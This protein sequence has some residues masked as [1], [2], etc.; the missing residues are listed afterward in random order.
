MLNIFYGRENIDKEK[1]IFDNIGGRA[2]LLVPDQFTLEAE[3]DLFEYSG[4]KAL[5][6]IEILS[7]SRLGYRLLSEL[8]GSKRTFIDKYGRHMILTEIAAREKDKLQ[9]F[10]GLEEKNSFIELVNNFI[11]ELKQYNCGSRELASIIDQVQDDSYVS[12]KLKDLALL[13]GAYEK[14]IEGKYTDSEDYIDL[15]MGKIGQSKL[16]EGNNIWIY[17]FDS[18]APKALPIIGELVECA[19]SVNVVLAG[20]DDLSAKDSQL[21]DLFRIV[22]K[23]LINIASKKGVP[24][25]LKPVPSDY[26]FTNKACGITVLEKELYA[27]P[28]KVVTDPSSSVGLT[29]TVAANP[30]NEAE[31]AASYVLHLVRD[32]G[33]KFNEI[34]VV[35]NDTQIRGSILKR[36]FREYGLDLI[37]DTGKDIL[38]NHIIQYV[39]SLIDVVVEKYR[40]SSVIRVLKSGFCDLTW[41]EISDLENYIIKYR[42]KG[43]MWK[44]PFTKGEKEYGVE[45]LKALDDIRFAAIEPLTKFEEAFKSETNKE[46]I[47]KL[48]NF[49]FDTVKLPDKIETLIKEQEAAGRL[50]LS[51]ETAQIWQSLVSIL[52]QMSEIDGNGKFDPPLF[53]QLLQAGLSQ[54]KLGVLPPAIDGLIMGTMQRTRTGKIRALLVVGANEGILPQEKPS[55]GLF[56]PEEKDLFKNKGVELCKSENIRLMEERLAIYR[57]LSAPSEMLWI[58]ASLTDTEGN[59]IK[60]SSVFSAVSGIFTCLNV[61]RDILSYEDSIDLVS[62]GTAGLRHMTCALQAAA[63]GKEFNSQWKLAL[64]WYK[65]NHSESIDSIRRGISFSNSQEDLGRELASSLFKKDAREDLSLSP[66]RLEKF[67]RCPFSHFIDYGLKPEERRIFEVAPRE[68]GD[69]YHLCLKELAQRITDPKI[70][71]TS[72]ESKWMTITQEECRDI[73]DKIISGESFKYREGLFVLGN[74]EEY[75]TRRIADVCE[76]VCWVVIEQVRA[77]KIESCD[78]EVPF[79]RNKKIKPIEIALNEQ[80]VYIEGKIDRVDYLCDDRVKIIDYKT[81]T[82]KFSAEQA[83]AGYRL[84]LMLYLVASM[85]GKRKPAGVFYLNISQPMTDMSAGSGSKQ[86]LQDQIRKQFKLNGIIVS[87][88]SVIENMDSDF[89]GSSDIIPVQKTKAGFKESKSLLSEEEF[90]QLTDAVTDK[91]NELVSNLA[92]GCMSI[93][94]MKTK[95]TSACAYCRYRGICR[96]DTVFAGCS[97]NIIQ[98]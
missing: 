76:K 95:N 87:D 96:F 37:S 34:K 74:Q 3:R 2:L 44:K 97:Y 67:S 9:I 81:G 82:E 83:A 53:S 41:N 38:Q 50:D 72:P 61:K 13:Y 79:G 89:T 51:E 52:D 35:C 45:G 5:T 20:D 66:S 43:S 91:V 94:P 29:L 88:E 80:K 17:G 6:D 46:F 42:I 60:P 54:M 36:I 28:Q 62:S 23:K 77:G 19:E 40:S 12:K 92:A 65:H 93:H 10:Q 69:I 18:F 85:E 71:V 57:N 11:S 1:F 68:I 90:S 84:Q 64:N 47:A 25:H 31:S 15:F 22:S 33:Y 56:G 59:T 98:E 30:Y 27:L 63:D 73:V 58:S 75:K 86:N 4:A 16:I 8:G 49:L 21:F 14:K 55:P 26:T 32:L 48:Y 24:C 7:M 70:A 39:I 78:F